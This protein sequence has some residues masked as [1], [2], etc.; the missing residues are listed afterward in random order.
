MCT[1]EKMGGIFLLTLTGVDEHRLNPAV[2]GSLRSSLRQVKDQSTRGSVLVTRN[3]GKFFSNG[4]DLE[5]VQSSGASSGGSTYNQ[6]FNLS[7][8]FR[9]LVA[10]FV[11]LPM[12]TITAVTGHAAASGMMLVSSHDYVLMRTLRSDRGYNL[13]ILHHHPSFFFDVGM[14]YPDYFTALV[15]EKVGSSMARRDILLKAVKMKA[16]EAMAVGVV[17]SVHESPEATVE[18]AVRLGEE[19]VKRKWDGEVYSDIRLAMYPELCGVLGLAPKG[20]RGLA[21]EDLLASMARI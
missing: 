18:A 17:D 13:F 15:R 7:E 9:P 4:F 11:S 12:P 3:Q 2:I 21:S 19:L 14:A 5:W 16:T 1:L 20:V 8:L 6:L 10:D